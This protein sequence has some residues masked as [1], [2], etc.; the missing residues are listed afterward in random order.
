MCLSLRPDHKAA[1]KWLP[2]ELAGLTGWSADSCLAGEQVGTVVMMMGSVKRT[3]AWSSA[4][5][6]ACVIQAYASVSALSNTCQ[7]SSSKDLIRRNDTLE[8][9]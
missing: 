8:V 9:L 5:S 2:C 1:S 7:S 4:T 3:G 6:S